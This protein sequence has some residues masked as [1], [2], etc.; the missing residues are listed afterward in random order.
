ENVQPNAVNP[1]E[2]VHVHVGK[3][4]Q[5]RTA[6]AVDAA[7]AGRAAHPGRP[8]DGDDPLAIDHDGAL[9][10]GR[11][12]VA[13]DDPHICDG[14]RIRARQVRGQSEQGDADAAHDSFPLRLGTIAR[15]MIA[16][17]YAC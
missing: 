13:V 16:T 11:A 14:D 8:A 9:L 1:A 4:R 7:G 2:Q 12:A 3:S 17:Y 10:D 6:L 15:A 5:H